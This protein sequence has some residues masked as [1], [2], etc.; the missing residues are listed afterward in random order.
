[1]A[2]GQSSSSRTSQGSPTSSS[3][4]SGAR[5]STW[6]PPPDGI[7]R[8][9]ARARRDLSTSSCSTSSFRGPT[10]STVLATCARPSRPCRSSRSR[11]SA[12]SR[13][14]VR[15]STPAPSTTWS[16]RSPSRARRP[17]PGPAPARVAPGPQTSLTRRR[18]R[19]RPAHAGRS[20]AQERPVRLSTTEFEL[21]AYL[22]RN[23]GRVLKREQILRAV[24]GY[25]HDPG[26]QRRR[27]LRRLSAAQA[28]ST[29]DR[30]PITTVR[31][32]GY[33]FDGADPGRSRR[34]W[35]PARPRTA[36]GG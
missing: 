28:A 18:D 2:S 35:R 16:S 3:A 24:W 14:G 31:S 20:A 21:L 22:M 11:P 26:D 1:M 9:P 10:G 30:H 4:A 27:C 36:A 32:V 15:A 17:H 29:D 5:A 7:S 12:R 34:R 6:S 25:D 13:I 33:R 19:A 23:R 8:D